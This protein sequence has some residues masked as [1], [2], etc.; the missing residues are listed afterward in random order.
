MTT[1]ITKI[2]RLSVVCLCILLLGS[3]TM[4]Y[5]KMK[6]IRKRAVFHGDEVCSV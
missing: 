6:L 4:R 2:V 1:S 3:A 5:M